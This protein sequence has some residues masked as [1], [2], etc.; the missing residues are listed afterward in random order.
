MNSRRYSNRRRRN[1]SRSGQPVW[2]WLGLAAGVA[3]LALVVVI[4]VRNAR[5]GSSGNTTTADARS[6][7]TTAPTGNVVDMDHLKRLHSGMTEAQV[8]AILGAPSTIDHYDD[9]Q[10]KSRQLSWKHGDDYIAIAFV[11][12]LSGRPHARLHGDLLVGRN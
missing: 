11:N 4:V 8:R 3:V 10:G 6:S 2:L 1:R 7:G 9:A 12:G 5:T